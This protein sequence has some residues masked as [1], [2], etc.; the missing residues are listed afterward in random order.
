MPANV[1][2]E[3][4][5]AEKEF[6]ASKTMDEQIIAMEKM[7]STMPQH[8]SAEA[9]RA[10]LRTRYKKLLEK[11]DKSKKSGKTTKVGIKKDFISEEPIS[12]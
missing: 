2:P 5:H 8:K 7:I 3:F 6:H 12:F 10:N 4:A 11:K 1:H 9:L